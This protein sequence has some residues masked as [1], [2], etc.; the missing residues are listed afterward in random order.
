MASYIELLERFSDTDLR[1]RTE[2]AVVVAAELI[3]S[4]Q[5]NAANGFIEDATMAGAHDTR[6]AWA[7]TAF[8]ETRRTAETILKAVL[9]QNKDATTQQIDDANDAQLQTNVNRAVD[10]IAGNIA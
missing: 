5:D 6:K 10:L 8:N 2:V 9:A 3:R 7:Q 4:G 1:N